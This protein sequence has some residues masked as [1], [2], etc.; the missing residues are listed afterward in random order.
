M[1][2]FNKL[3]PGTRTEVV[4]ILTS[5]LFYTLTGNPIWFATLLAI[6]VTALTIHELSV[7]L[8]IQ[9]HSGRRSSATA[10]GNTAKTYQSRK[11][12]KKLPR[13]RIEGVA[14]T[15]TA[16]V[17]RFETSQATIK[18]KSR[19]TGKRQAAALAA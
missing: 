7:R 19:R 11:Q 6:V 5:A 18:Q 10:R 15:H 9:S 16:K 13:L 12:L 8:H 2:Q 4:S 17:D 14:L 1:K 3:S